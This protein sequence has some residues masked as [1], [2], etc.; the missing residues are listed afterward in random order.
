MAARASFCLLAASCG[1]CHAWKPWSRSEP[2]S[3][4]ALQSP[5]GDFLVVDSDGAGRLHKAGWTRQPADESV[6]LQFS[7][8]SGGR[9]R[10]H[11]H[12]G[13]ALSASATAGGDVWRVYTRDDGRVA[14]CS[15]VTGAFVR[16]SG[17]DPSRRGRLDDEAVWWVPRQVSPPPVHGA[18]STQPSRQAGAV[19]RRRGGGAPRL[20]P[21]LAYAASAAVVVGSTLALSGDKL[22][23]GLLSPG[24]SLRA[25]LRWACDRL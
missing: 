6:A 8:L 4:F 18:V 15:A 5:D 14:L 17:F 3:V 12:S 21:H 19:R 11:G 22:G 2:D 25:C 9:Y 13:V 20:T 10:V 7:A 16:V 1:S 24:S 23:G